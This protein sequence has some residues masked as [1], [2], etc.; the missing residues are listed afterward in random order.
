LS[1]LGFTCY[2]PELKK[3]VILVANNDTFLKGLLKKWEK[4]R[5]PIRPSESELHFYESF[6]TKISGLE[7]PEMLILGATPELRDMG[8]KYGM[9]PV[10]ADIEKPIWETM[11][12]FMK[13][14]G[15][16]ELILCDWLELPED[17]KF[18]L[19]LGD[20]PFNML[21]EEKGDPFFESVAKVTKDDGLIVQRIITFNDKLTLEDFK[22]AVRDFRGNHS[23]LSLYAN[24]VFLANSIGKSTYPH[25]TQLEI[26]E[27]VLSKYLTKDELD[28]VIPNLLPIKI[29][30]PSRTDL[31]AMLEKHFVLEQVRESKG[32]GYWDTT[33]QYVARKK[34]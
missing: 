6:V 11:K 26:F 5:E 10:C 19:I 22:R 29:N 31:K 23:E 16:E 18:D 27:Q 34:L 25:L 3:E 14:Q 1:K 2:G 32:P 7:N 4:T 8:I 24:T 13:E 33:A 28:E 30:L 17:R 15:E 9:K 20:G 12:H 21:A